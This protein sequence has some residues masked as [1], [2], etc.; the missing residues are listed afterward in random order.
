[1]DNINWEALTPEEMMENNKS[2]EKVFSAVYLGAFWPSQDVQVMLK[3][4]TFQRRKYKKRKNY[5]PPKEEQL[6]AKTLVKE[7]NK[8]LKQYPTL[9][10]THDSEYGE[11]YV[12]DLHSEEILRGESLKTMKVSRRYKY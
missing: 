1:M 9:E 10:L 3:D 12:S 4:G 5:W 8:L 6:R 7:L 2:S 11:W